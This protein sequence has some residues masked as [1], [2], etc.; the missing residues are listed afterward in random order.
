MRFHTTF[1]LR[2]ASKIRHI[3][4]I[5]EYFGLSDEEI[6]ALESELRAHFQDPSAKTF[7][8]RKM[9]ILARV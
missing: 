2:Q 7:K 4:E 6:D 5:G 3:D 1:V 8:F 9:F